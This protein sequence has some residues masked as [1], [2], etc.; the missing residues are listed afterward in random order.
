MYHLC[1]MS[2]KLPG[3]IMSLSCNHTLLFHLKICLSN[4]NLSGTIS[5][6]QFHQEGDQLVVLEALL[7]RQAR[8]T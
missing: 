4:H 8:R 1:Y 2:V 3:W 5:T 7:T 6:K